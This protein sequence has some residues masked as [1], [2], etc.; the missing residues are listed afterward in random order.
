MDA[1]GIFDG[2]GVKGA[3]LAG[4]LKGAQEAGVKFVGYGGTS[5]GSIVALLASV[6]YSANELETIMCKQLN[7]IDFLDDSGSALD[8]WKE[9][10]DRIVEAGF[11]V[12]G[13]FGLWR[14]KGELKA[15]LDS[16]GLYDGAK[17]EQRLRELVF[18]KIPSLREQSVITFAD[19][20]QNG[21]LPLKVV[22]SNLRSRRCTVLSAEQGSEVT[23]VFTAVRAS[24]SYPL[25]FRPVMVHK[26]ALVDGGL[27]S[28]LPAWLF[29]EERN[30]D[31]LPVIAFDLT[32]R[33]RNT[34]SEDYSVRDFLSDMLDTALE[35]GDELLRRSSGRVMHIEVPIDP[36]IRTLDFSLCEKDRQ[37]LFD[38]GYRETLS[39]FM[40]T[41][42]A[43]GV[44]RDPVGQLV[45][46][47][48]DPCVFQAALGGLLA[49]TRAAYPN[50]GR[51]RAGITLPTS[52]GDQ[53]IVVY[54]RGMESDP[55]VDLLLDRLGGPSGQA[56]KVEK[57]LIADWENIRL[58]PEG[59]RM[60]KKQ[61]VKI[62][63]DRRAVASIPV[64][65]LRRAVQV[66]QGVMR[67]LRIVGA[68]SL[69]SDQPADH[70]GW[71]DHT[72]TPDGE[73]VELLKR[74]SDVVGRVLN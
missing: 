23:D 40:R 57:P 37:T 56:V 72:G 49:E 1:Y 61:A 36:D 41:F 42:G 64:F 9:V 62:P 33:G 44:L 60:T 52:L 29:N 53:S 20:R 48:G 73:F 11:G 38:D 32:T 8:R 69:D 35:S 66:D 58:N 47:Y 74:W 43:Q 17:L 45:A 28:N 4:A 55:D 59:F 18:A 31:N 68:L 13:A 3:A 5:A 65:D 50:C 19:L 67:A 26:A 10:V 51:L 22:A 2:G 16:R 46:V 25:L 39:F 63:A 21:A 27:A 24:A 12:M 71:T 34:P 54:N 15:L 6:G 7:F 70:A 14:R 30:R